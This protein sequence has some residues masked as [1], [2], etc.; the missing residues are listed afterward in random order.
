[1]QPHPCG[2]CDAQ[3]VLQAGEGLLV[4]AQL[5]VQGAQFTVGLGLLAALAAQ[6]V[7]HHQPLLQAH[8]RLL[9]AAHGPAARGGQAHVQYSHMLWEGGGGTTSP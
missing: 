3:L 7:G 4:V 5:A 8:Q 2:A 9:Q 6:L 1:M